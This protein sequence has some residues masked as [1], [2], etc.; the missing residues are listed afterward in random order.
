MFG[1]LECVMNAH[2]DMSV[3]YHS[4]DLVLGAFRK[5][6]PCDPFVL[7]RDFS[8]LTK[9][10]MIS[11]PFFSPFVFSRVEKTT[12]ARRRSIGTQVVTLRH[13]DSQAVFEGGQRYALQRLGIQPCDPIAEVEEIMTKEK[14]EKS[15]E[16]RLHYRVRKK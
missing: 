9:M 12:W 10:T 6:F 3:S 2:G 13:A 5:C 7:S 16:V 11:P 15:T 14:S 8:R 4:A 1:K